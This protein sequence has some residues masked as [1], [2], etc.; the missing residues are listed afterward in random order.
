MVELKIELR[1]HSLCDPCNLLL[2]G[3]QQDF[4][5]MFRKG[6]PYMRERAVF[7]ALMIA[8]PSGGAGRS[9]DYSDINTQFTLGMHSHTA[10]T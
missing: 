9:R 8:I 6:K 3:C 7:T 5:H 2:L 10:L 4:L 1:H